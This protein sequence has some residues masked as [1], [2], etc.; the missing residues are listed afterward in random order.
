MSRTV[1]IDELM[2]LARLTRIAY[3]TPVKFMTQDEVELTRRFAK[4][5]TPLLIE[6][7]CLRIIELETGENSSD[8]ST[9]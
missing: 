4:T 6:S 1:M 7:L 2:I 9:Q 8:A 3:D 5:F